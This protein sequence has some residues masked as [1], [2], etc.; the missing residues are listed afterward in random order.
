[1]LLQINFIVVSGL[2]FLY[3]TGAH[4]EVELAE[5]IAFQTKQ[6]NKHTDKQT[7]KQQKRKTSPIHF[8]QSDRERG[9]LQLPEIVDDERLRQREF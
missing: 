9:R 8:S 6:I 4:S 2:S 1:M 3:P 7:N 5:V